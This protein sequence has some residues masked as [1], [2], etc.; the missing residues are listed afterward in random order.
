MARTHR[1]EV[2]HALRATIQG[3]E[4]DSDI[5]SGN[6]DLATLK[7]ILV[8]RIAE[9]E[10]EDNSAEVSEQS[11]SEAIFGFQVRNFIP[12]SFE[13]SRQRESN[14]CHVGI[15]L[16]SRPFGVRA[17]HTLTHFSMLFFKIFHCGENC[18]AMRSH[19]ELVAIM[20]SHS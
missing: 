1:V 11:W 16:D 15:S 20:N 3:L 5:P 8:R 10:R 6:A 13:I 12:E 4:Q 9:L 19:L 2:I 17:A 18:T 14:I 7:A